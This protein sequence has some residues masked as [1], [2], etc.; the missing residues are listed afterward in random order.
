VCPECPGAQLVR[1]GGGLCRGQHQ[2]SSTRSAGGRGWNFLI[3]YLNLGLSAGLGGKVKIPSPIRSNF[4]DRWRCE[5]ANRVLR[6]FRKKYAFEIEQQPTDP[7]FT[8]RSGA[9]QAGS[10]LG[11]HISKMRAKWC[12]NGQWRARRATTS[13]FLTQP[14]CLQHMYKLGGSSGGDGRLRLNF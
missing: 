13:H 14:D 12:Q 5:A 8:D 3:I 6:S 11:K 1:A 10:M 9:L 7:G 2:K 4:A